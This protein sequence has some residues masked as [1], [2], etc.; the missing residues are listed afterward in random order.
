VQ[1]EEK[2]HLWLIFLIAGLFFLGQLKTLA[3]PQD[4]TASSGNSQGRALPEIV[5]LPDFLPLQVGNKWTYL[6]KDSRYR[7]SDRIKI[8][9]VSTTIIQW[10]SYYVFNNLPFIP[11]LDPLGTLFIRYDETNRRYVRLTREGEIPLFP[12]GSS[13]NSK[14]DQSVDDQ[15][16]PVPGRLSYLT[17]V[18][19]SS[20]GVEI[21]FDKG[22]GISAVEGTYSWGTDSYSLKSAVVNGKNIGEPPEEEKIQ[23][24]KN[25]A[26]PVISRADPELF[27]EVDKRE[28]GASLILTVKNPAENMLSL[29]FETSQN[30]DFL[31]REKETG[32]ILWRWSQGNYF[33]KVGRNLALLPGQQWRYEEFWDFKDNQHYLLKPGIYEV[34]GALATREPRETQPVEITLP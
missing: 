23:K 28:H 31:V 7:S 30:Y 27:L 34:A 25:R 13:A 12:V 9:I 16:K 8:E 11:G 17:C 22:V 26:G 14:F 29:N 21:I 20:T 1:P 6:H 32:R 10:K 4:Q 33:S 15:D 5:L 18:S 24:K 3:E 2:K 19:C